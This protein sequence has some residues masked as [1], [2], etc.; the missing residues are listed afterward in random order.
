MQL[1]ALSYAGGMA[2]GGIFF[3]MI[4]MASLFAAAALMPMLAA[5]SICGERLRDTYDLMVLSLLRPQG[6]IFAKIASVAGMFFC[7]ALGLLPLFGVTFFYVGVDPLQFVQAIS[8]VI[9]SAITSSA[10]GVMASAYARRTVAAVITAILLI[11]GYYGGFVL[12]GGLMLLLFFEERQINFMA[13]FFI[14]A[15]PVVMLGMSFDRPLELSQFLAHMGYQVF[16]LLLAVI[17]GR[18]Y[19]LRTRV[20]PLSQDP[21]HE[22]EDGLPRKVRIRRRISVPL[23]M[24][25]I[26]DGH[27]AMRYKELTTGPVASFIM[28]AATFLGF[29]CL[30]LFITGYVGMDAYWNPDQTP[31]LVAIFIMLISFLSLIL[32]PALLAPTFAREEESDQLDMLRVTLLTPSEIVKGKVY[33]A[34]HSMMWFMLGAF[35][36]VLGFSFAPSLFFSQ[37]DLL[38]ILL[39][40]LQLVATMT[41]AIGLTLLVSVRQRTEAGAMIRSAAWLFFVLFVLPYMLMMSLAFAREI[42]GLEIFSRRQEW[43]YVSMG[44]SPAVSHLATATQSAEFLPMLVVLAFTHIA[45]GLLLAKLSILRYA[46]RM[47]DA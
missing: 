44:I 31:A 15:S 25:E 11:V 19:L 30:S 34:L 26:P 35:T 17:V 43:E 1:G 4:C 45:V 41:F 37:E 36:G 13:E 33:G 7:I 21:A 20:R 46:K 24:R 9:I 6:I 22:S 39:S 14:F 18:R 40:L 2:P 12:A 3:G 23:R 29:A 8:I 27:N 47:R 38:P 28:R 16:M 5:P 10:I 32:I 42:L